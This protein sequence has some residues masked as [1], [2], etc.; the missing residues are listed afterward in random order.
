M[1]FAFGV[2]VTTK[3]GASKWPEKQGPS[4]L[5]EG[6]RGSLIGSSSSRYQR[7][8]EPVGGSIVKKS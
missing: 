1:D 4:T 7:E 2:S 3:S 5:S 8:G 6:R